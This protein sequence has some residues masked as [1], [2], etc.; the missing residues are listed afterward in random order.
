MVVGGLLEGYPSAGLHNSPDRI[1]VIQ[2]WYQVEQG[3]DVQLTHTILL[4]LKVTGVRAEHAV[5]SWSIYPKQTWYD[6]LKQDS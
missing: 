1:E 2:D 5:N 3:I 6:S 4:Q